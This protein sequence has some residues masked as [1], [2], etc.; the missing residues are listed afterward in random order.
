VGPG[1]TALLYSCAP[2]RRVIIFK[3]C[4]WEKMGIEEVM[5]GKRRGLWCIVVVEE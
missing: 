5:E 2:A 1:P 3:T 4:K